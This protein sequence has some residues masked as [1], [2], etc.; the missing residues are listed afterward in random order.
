VPT[1][2][3]LEA[4][5]RTGTRRLVL[6]SSLAVY[7]WSA[8]GRVLDEASPLERRL[9][10]RDGYAVSKTW[11]ERLCRRHAQA[12]GV[13][14][15]ILRPGF[16]WARE[17]AWVDG[18]G[19]R[20]G[21]RLLVV[22][23]RH[24]L[25]LVH[26]ESCAE[27]VALAVACDAADGEALNLVDSDAVDAWHHA[28]ALLRSGAVDARRRVALPYLLGLVLSLGA[29]AL[30]RAFLGPELRLP[31]LLVPER[32]RARF[33]SL[34]FANERAQRVLGWKPAATGERVDR[35]LRGA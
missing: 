12:H 4:M 21:G 26:V 11:Q 28:G 34:R 8:P 5:A 13:R 30:G 19:L 33:R 6:V 20:L 14:L 15:S 24:R 31:G 35:E 2:A 27:A 9:E 29:S 23:P 16:L 1:E 22:G 25:P 32:Y 10:R 3:L 7:D 18:V 17:R